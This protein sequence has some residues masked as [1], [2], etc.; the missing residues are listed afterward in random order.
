MPHYLPFVNNNTA[1]R[2]FRH[3]LA[4]DERRAKFTPLFHTLSMNKDPEAKPEPD[5]TPG[6]SLSTLKDAIGASAG[7]DDKEGGDDQ[8]QNE[9]SEYEKSVNDATGQ[10]TDALEVW[11]AGAHTGKCLLY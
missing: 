1:I 8:E 3:A 5:M 7:G 10:T 4:L 6:A 2:Y 9:R 11:F